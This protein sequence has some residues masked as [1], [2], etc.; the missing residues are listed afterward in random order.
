[1]SNS[2]NNLY[3]K[4]KYLYV[5]NADYLDRPY[6]GSK[7]GRR[8]ELD[9]IKRQIE[10]SFFAERYKLRYDLKRGEIYEFDWGINVNAEF[11]N[12]HYGVVLADSN[13][14]NPLVIVCPL[15]SNHNGAHPV[16]DIDLGVLPF[17]NT[18]TKTVAVINQVRTLDKLRI[19]TRQVINDNDVLRENDT[20][21]NSVY[22]LDDKKVDLIAKAYFNMISGF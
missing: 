6:P 11:C 8:D 2:N 4:G 21:T 17:L 1:M 19:Y 3:G 18:T 12:R 16:S 20:F 15:K 13:Q 7:I 14:Y 9:W 10:Y 5:D 22:R